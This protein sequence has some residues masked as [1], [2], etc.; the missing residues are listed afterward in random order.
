MPRQASKLGL[1]FG[2]ASV[3]L[4]TLAGLWWALGSFS[5][6][7]GEQTTQGVDGTITTTGGC[8]PAPSNYESDGLLGVLW[9][10]LPA[11]LAL[12]ALALTPVASIRAPARWAVASAVV[13]LSLLTVFTPFMLLLLPAGG[14][15]VLA[16]VYADVRPPEEPVAPDLVD[17]PHR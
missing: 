7:C 9:L 3:S 4:L 11:F 1:L 13:L 17:A 10:G 5:T 15:M 2:A 6:P 14:L 16:A 8:A 12:S